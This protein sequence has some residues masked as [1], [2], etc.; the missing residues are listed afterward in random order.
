MYNI[1][2]I[3]SFMNNLNQMTYIN[4]WFWYERS[5]FL[6][7]AVRKMTSINPRNF[8]TSTTRRAGDGGMRSRESLSKQTCIYT[9]RFPSGRS[10]LLT[11]VRPKQ[12]EWRGAVGHI[13]I[14]SWWTKIGTYVCR[15]GRVSARGERNGSYG[16]W[17]LADIPSG[18]IVS[19]ENLSDVADLS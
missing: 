4:D 15:I 8:C 9:I 1:N 10:T 18:R 19:M 7:I 13:G 14:C 17:Q 16:C 3:L 5:K 12:D 6:E 2:V 11:A